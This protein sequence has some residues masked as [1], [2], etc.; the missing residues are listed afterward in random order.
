MKRYVWLGRSFIALIFT[1]GVMCQSVFAA[2]LVGIGSLT[3]P[4]F[5]SIPVGISADGSAVAGDSIS[6]NGDEAFYWTRDSGIIGLGDLPGG[7]F[8]SFAKDISSNNQVVVGWSVSDFIQEAFRWTATEGM[9]GLGTLDGDVTGAFSVAY[10]TSADGDVVV[11]QSRSVSGPEAFYWTASDGMVGLGDLPGGDFTSLANDVTGNGSVVVGWSASTLSQ[12][13]FRWTKTDGMI[14]LGTLL[15]GSYSVADAISLDGSTIVGRGDSINGIEE[16][17]YWTAS[18]GLVGLG[19]LP[20]GTFSSA[21]YGVTRNGDIIVGRG[22]SVAGSEAVV[23]GIDR[24]IK[25]VAQLLTE[26]G[27]DLNGWHLISALD[28]SENG[29]ITGAAT[30]PNGSEAYIARLA[31]EVGLIGVNDFTNSLGDVEKG[32]ELGH[33]INGMM[34]RVVGNFSSRGTGSVPGSMPGKTILSPVVMYADGSEIMAAGVAVE[35]VFD[36]L[37]IKA[38]VAGVDAED[39]GRYN[40]DLELTGYSLSLALDMFPGKMMDSSAIDP[41]NITIGLVGGFYDGD[42]DRTYLN[43]STPDTSNGEPDVDTMAAFIEAGW[44]FVLTEK[45]S[46]RP[47]VELFYQEVEMDSY[48]ESGGSFPGRVS[49]QDEDNTKYSLGVEGLWQVN[50]RFKVGADVVGVKLSDDQGPDLEVSVP[51][52]GTFVYPGVDYDDTWAEFAFNAQWNFTSNIWLGGEVRG[53]SG[54][55]YPEDWSAS[56]ELSFMF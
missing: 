28:I 8:T 44:S 11:G 26:E 30:S 37:A 5:L 23:W 40:G 3:G 53:A 14:G 6:A 50:D 32:F 36:A 22:N 46:I 18:E 48:T 35:H 49:S 51:D 24:E 17:F 38:A 4:S 27:I 12:E 1:C 45:A 7:T 39:D 33:K 56:A 13:A 19:D 16:A 25:S 42:F 20:G 41:L 31:E 9:R 54:S 52:V 55:D 34:G 21:A 43:G 29:V 10:A 15:G 2:D 47:F